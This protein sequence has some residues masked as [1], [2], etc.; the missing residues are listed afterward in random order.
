MALPT[1]YYAPW[2]AIALVA[3]TA[4]T[5]LELPTA[6]NRSI[7]L[8]ELAISL[9]VTTATGI[10]TIEMGTFTTTGTGTALTAQ[11]W[12]GNLALAST[13]LGTAKVADTVEPAG[14]SVGTLG[15]TMYPSLKIPLPAIPF[16]QFPLGDEFTVPASTNFGIRLTSTIA[17]NTSGW[18]R[19]DE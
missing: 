18:I 5:I 2:A 12:N 6:A 7:A 10:L 17:G 11:K 16:F 19:W 14:F 3:S 1:E 4:K 13:A 9:D 8:K 15:G